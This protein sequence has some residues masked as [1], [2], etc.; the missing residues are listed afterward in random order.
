LG[1]SL[2]QIG[3]LGLPA[4]LIERVYSGQGLDAAER[5]AF[6]QLY[7]TGFNLLNRIPRL[8]GIAEGIYYQGKDY[9]GQGFPED[10]VAGKAIPLLGRL[11]KVLFNYQI[12]LN[13]GHDSDEVMS[14]LQETHG[15]YDPNILNA[16]ATELIQ[17]EDG[18]VLK[19]LGVYEL[20]AGMLVAEDILTN[21][22]ILL[23]KKRSEINDINILRLTGLAHEGK[24]AKKIKVLVSKSRQ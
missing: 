2:S 17:L 6:S 24:I 19:E 13:A 23:M 15:I 8:A 4:D 10:D 3:V 14:Y 11:L 12:M 9:N 21:T 20:R 16:L 22:G 1:A 7:E 5:E 18:L